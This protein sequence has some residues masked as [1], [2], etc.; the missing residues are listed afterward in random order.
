MQCTQLTDVIEAGD[1]N[2][3]GCGVYMGC[4]M[5]P[6]DCF[7]ALDTCDYVLTWHVE[8]VSIWFQLTAKMYSHRVL[9]TAVGLNDHPQMVS[10]CQYEVTYVELLFLT[11]DILAHIEL[12][13]HPHISSFS[14]VNVKNVLYVFYTLLCHFMF[15]TASGI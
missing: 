7:Y 11:Q 8:E 14:N 10:V 15:R 3:A 2:T 9:W 4:L 13:C 6:F 1:I 12:E 5:E